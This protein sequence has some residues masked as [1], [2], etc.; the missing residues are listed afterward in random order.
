MAGSGPGRREKTEG[1]R[2]NKNCNT[3]SHRAANY[4]RIT[5]SHRGRVKFGGK[6][7]TLNTKIQLREIL[8]T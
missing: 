3:E 6:T 7:K 5:G 4:G 2:E 1:R 8:R